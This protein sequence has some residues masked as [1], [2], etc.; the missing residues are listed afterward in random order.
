MKFPQVSADLSVRWCSA[1]LKIDVG[2][3]LMNN[4]PQFQGQ[5]T[6]FITGERAQESTA[7]AKYLE[8]EEHHSSGRGRLIHQWRPILHWDEQKVW[9]IIKRHRILPHPCYRLGWGRASCMTCIFGSP[10]QWATVRVIAPE[11]FER[12][13]QYEEEFGLTIQRKLSIRQMADK[14]TPYMAACNRPELIR[15]A[16]YEGYDEVV[17]VP[18]GEWVLPAGAFGESAGPT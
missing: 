2:R 17:R 14:G 5:K 10:N 11:Q 7:R 3:I 9:E 12:I 8:A 18:E 4:D 1:Y 15:M 16:L 6:L 13:A